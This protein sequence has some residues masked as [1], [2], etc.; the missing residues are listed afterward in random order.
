MN[1]LTC[2]QKGFLILWIIPLKFLSLNLFSVFTFTNYFW[3]STLFAN[4][5]VFIYLTE[6]W[7]YAR[8][9]NIKYDI[10]LVPFTFIFKAIRKFTRFLCISLRS[11]LGNGKN[12]MFLI[13]FQ[14][15]SQ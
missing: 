3:K 1:E 11:V 5:H 13:E 9:G 6:K 12:T 15:S 10:C 14:T 7:F 2:I 4:I 8:G